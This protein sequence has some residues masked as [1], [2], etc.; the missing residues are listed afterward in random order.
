MPP[1]AKPIYPI[2]PIEAPPKAIPPIPPVAEPSEVIPPVPPVAE[3]SEVILPKPPV[4]AAPEAVAP[5]VALDAA[6]EADSA[7]TIDPVSET[8]ATPADTAFVAA[9]LPPIGNTVVRQEEKIVSDQ[10]LS[11][12]APPSPTIIEPNQDDKFAKLAN[13]VSATESTKNIPDNANIA[14]PTIDKIQIPV[15]ELSVIAGKANEDI[16]FNLEGVG[17]QYDPPQE[18]A[19]NIM[20]LDQAYFYSESSFKFRFKDAGKY[21]LTFSKVNNNTASKKTQTIVFDIAAGDDEKMTEVKPPP[22]ASTT[23]AAAVVE[24]VVNTPVV[25]DNSATDAMT[26]TPDMMTEEKTP[27]ELPS[28][29]PVSM[30]AVP[31]KPSEQQLIEKWMPLL[32]KRSEDAKDFLHSSDLYAFDYFGR[33]NIIFEMAEKLNK[34]DKINDKRISYYLYNEL[35]KQYPVSPKMP[36]VKA[37]LRDADKNT[38]KPF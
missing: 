13:P 24:P 14:L 26:S 15:E 4:K 34:S 9:A 16:N 36:Q 35:L 29:S 12:E 31:G 6:T 37:R 25:N 28:L 19:E 20:F 27:A 38:F 8:K 5:I 17:W 3:S 33:A 32:E 2:P 23:V 7:K 11:K 10:G 21:D 1:D 30:E 18:N 22:V